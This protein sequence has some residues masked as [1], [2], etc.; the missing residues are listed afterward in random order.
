[1]S[2]HNPDL[3]KEFKISQGHEKHGVLCRKNTINSAYALHRHDYLEVEYLV[4]GKIIHEVNGVEQ[5]MS[6]GDCW[7]LNNR[8]MHM[9][10]ANKPAKINSICIDLKNAPESIKQFLCMFKFPMTGYI[11][12][13]LAPEI[14]RLYERLTEETLSDNIYAKE[15]INAYLILILT[16]I[17]ENSQTLTSNTVA[18]GYRYI[19]KAIEYMWSNFSRPLTLAEVANKVYLSPNYFSKLFVE[20]SGINFLDYLSNMRIEKSKEMLANTNTPVTFIAMDCGFGSFS[21]FSRNFKKACG[22]T[23]TAYRNLTHNL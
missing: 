20:V 4:Q 18:S 14:N 15:R 17:F 19:T 5:T 9:F 7:C 3:I 2:V 12:K 13:E 1:M 8:D 11:P 10:T 16:Y 21:S 6:A 23:P 22:C